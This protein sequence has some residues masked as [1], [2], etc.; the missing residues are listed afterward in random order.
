MANALKVLI[1]GMGMLFICGTALAAETTVG[2]GVSVGEGSSMAYNLNVRQ[3]YEP[4]LSGEVGELQ[5]TAEL[6]GFAW[7]DDDDTVWGASL[8]PGLRFTLFTTANFQPY[9]EGSVGGAVISDEKLDSRDLGS[10]AL[11]KTKGIVGVQFG[12][13]MRHRVQGEYTNYSTWGLTDT[14]DG[15]STVGVSYGFSF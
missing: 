10:H 7:V 11:F 4:W 8:A 13:S 3:S 2:G 9:M 1:A 5:P 14:D 15:Y 12:E 6:S